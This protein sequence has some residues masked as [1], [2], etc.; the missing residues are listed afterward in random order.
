MS[1]RPR[2]LLAPLVAVA[3]GLVLGAGARRIGAERDEAERRGR[4]LA[5]ALD[6]IE[7]QRRTAEA[8]L[9]TVDVGLLLLDE[10]GR[11][12]GRNKRHEDFMALAFPDGHDGTAGQL[13][14]VRHADAVTV[15]ARDEMPTHRARL[16]EEFDDIR[17]W[18]GQGAERRALSVSARSIRDESGR[19]TGSALA[20]KDV[21][22][23]MEA[24]EVKD[25]F[26]ASV[27]HEL[28]TPL[29]SIAG[30]LDVLLE[31]ADLP[32][33]AVRHLEIAERNAH[34][35]ER[36]VADL[37]STA[38]ADASPTAVQ[39]ATVDLAA[40]VREQ[41]EAARPVAAARQVELVGCAAG[42]VAAYVDS[43]RVRQVVDNL[44]SNALK[45]TPAGGQVRVELVPGDDELEVCVSDT[46]P[47]I[48]PAE[49]DQVFGRFFRTR[50]ARDQVLPGVGLGLAITRDI[51]AAHDGRIE[52]DD[53][54][55]G[56]LRARV[57]LPRGGG[58]VGSGA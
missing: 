12:V 29:T 47:G 25:A 43:Q 51:V 6:T 18:V 39:R 33:Q 41:V 36:L 49:R 34:R 13:G 35:L 30:Y 1:V 42:E 55:G 28:R 53:A 38:V 58:A 3:S 23:F 5:A 15:M 52:L 57:L 22:D 45:H 19:Q 21:T 9:D 56:G 32:A 16:G 37:L 26:V 27:S 4:E 24:M 46:G 2:A 17:I 10:Q 40:L 50:A 8:I 20:Y 44:L 48:A 11:Y 7:H 54:P 14:Q 31:R